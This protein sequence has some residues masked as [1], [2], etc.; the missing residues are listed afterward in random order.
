MDRPAADGVVV[1]GR[2]PRRSRRAPG[3][4]GR[5]AT[6][7]G[8]RSSSADQS[9]AEAVR[10]STPSRWLPSI[11]K[12]CAS[13]CTAQTSF[14]LCL[15]RGPGAGLG[16]PVVGV[17]LEPE[18]VDA[19]DVAPAGQVARPGG[20][21]PGG[22]VAQL[23]PVAE[24]EVEVLGDLEREQVARVAQQRALQRAG[25][26]FPVAL[27]P[28]PGGAQ[29]M[30]LPLAHDGLVQPLQ[31]LARPRRRPPGSSR[32]AQVGAVDV[33]EHQA[34][35]GGDRRL[36]VGH[37]VTGQGGQVLDGFVEQ[38]HRVRAARPGREPPSDPRTP[39]PSRIPSAVSPQPRRSPHRSTG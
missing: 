39:L 4:T 11:S 30:E 8:W 16:L 37:R 29:V 33:A 3:G 34:V 38:G 19:L 26:G 1:Q 22:G 10:K 6:S 32:T 13:A 14:G 35:V 18:R 7:C 17:L 9:G 15:E 24:E 21:H 2:A 36:G 31:D 12:T 25:G 20:Q 27:G 5:G 23:E 28:V